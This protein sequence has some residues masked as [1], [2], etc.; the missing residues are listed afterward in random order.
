MTS[1]DAMPENSP[2][3]GVR[4]APATPLAVAGLAAAALLAT[5]LPTLI[6]LYEGPWQTEQEGHGPIII[7]GAFWIV[8]T[9]RQAL[10]Q[11]LFT[12]AP[13]LGWPLVAAGLFGLFLARILDFLPVE[14]LSALPV[15]AGC[16]L[17]FGG[18][19]LLRALAFA[20]FFLVFAVPVPDTII[21]ALTVP[22]KVLISNTVVEGLYQL[23]Y[24]IAQNGVLI[25]INAFHLLVKDACSGL[26]SI[27][28]LSAVGLFYVYMFRPAPLWR[29]TILLAAIVPI[30]IFANFI[31]VLTLVLIA[32]YGNPDL[33][34]T[35]VHDFTGIAL[36][37]LALTLL[38][39]L[40]TVVGY[41]MVL[42]G[43]LFA[44]RATPT[45]AA[46]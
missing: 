34:E 37:V 19:K 26:N 40:D 44:K 17:I 22:L 13:L 2:K 35:A 29:A 7:A 14:A 38:F 41:L 10:L 5:Y 23:G 18:I 16:A 43:W 20:I 33:L 21:V 39:L 25:Q 45:P 27:F 30:A 6:K 32:F 11:G 36:F 3:R 46:A 28:V 15:L 1:T 4:P 24:P 8:W 12:P 42:A 9:N 31:R